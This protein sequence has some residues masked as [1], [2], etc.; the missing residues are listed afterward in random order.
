PVRALRSV[1]E[2]E[3]QHLVERV[4]E[5]GIITAGI[6]GIDAEA[7]SGVVDRP[8]LVAQPVMPLALVALHEVLETAGA[9]RDGIGLGGAIGEKRRVLAGAEPGDAERSERDMRGNAAFAR[10]DDAPGFLAH[11][12]IRTGKAGE[13]V[14]RSPR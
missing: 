7:P 12:D 2:Q 11:R 6:D 3:W 13:V 5:F 8:G 4:A 1:H 9:R 10:D 14:A